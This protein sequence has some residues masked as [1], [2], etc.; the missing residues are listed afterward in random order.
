MNTSKY[1]NH[2]IT[3]LAFMLL[4]VQRFIFGINYYPTVDDWFLYMGKSVLIPQGLASPDLATRPFAG[5][6]DHYI[7]APLS[8]HLVIVEILLLIMLTAGVYFLWHAIN[9]N[10]KSTDLIFILM[11][12]MFPPAFEGIYWI[13]AGAR[14][15]PSIFFTGLSAYFLRKTLIA[16]PPPK[17]VAIYA[18]SGLFAVGFY[19]IFIPVYLIVCGGIILSERKKYWLFIIPVIISGAMAVYYFVNSGDV[20]ISGRLEFVGIKDLPSHLVYVI[21]QYITLIKKSAEVFH[22]SFVDGIKAIKT[23][24]LRGLMIIILATASGI[25]APK[26]EIEKKPQKLVLSLFLILGGMALNLIIAFVRVPFRLILP[27]MTG[28]AL[29][30]AVVLSYLPRVPYKII[31]GVMALIFSICNTGS[32]TLYKYT[33]QRDTEL[34]NSLIENYDVKDPEKYTYIINPP[35]YWYN[36]RVAYYEFVKATTENYAT[37]TGQAEYFLNTPI[38]NNIMCLYEGNSISAFTPDTINGQYLYY[39]GNTLVPCSLAFSDPGFDVV[40][41][42]GTKVGHITVENKLFTYKNIPQG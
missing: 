7:I 39:N 29:M 6:F 14:I 19:E 25:F 18:F 42:D 40:I 31:A 10:A 1:R 3:G 30:V 24:P 20:T 12:T 2:I 28:I 32:L 17:N 5:L 26:T 9:K 33:N 13:S 16:P 8:D 38:K 37:L 15:I 34:V 4:L 41:R 36:D 35:Q 23:Y 27:M 21:S 11:L 22:G